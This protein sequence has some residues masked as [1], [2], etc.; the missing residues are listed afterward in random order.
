MSSSELTEWMAYYKLE[1]FGQERDNYHAAMLAAIA[2]NS[3]RKKGAPAV[4]ISE[5][6][7]KDR[8]T[9][10]ETESQGF[11]TGLQALAKPKK[12]KHGKD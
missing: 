3:N 7:Y 6:M 10:K 5:F 4:P 11:L 12:A 2:V 9:Q 1:P 8:Y